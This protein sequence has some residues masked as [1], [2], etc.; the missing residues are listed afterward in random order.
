MNQQQ[1]Q[2]QYSL[3]EYLVALLII[4]AFMLGV[5]FAVLSFLAFIV[6]RVNGCVVP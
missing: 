1:Q 4:P 2:E 3:S 5:F 6:P